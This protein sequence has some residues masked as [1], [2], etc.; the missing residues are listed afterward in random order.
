[1]TDPWTPFRDPAGWLRALSQKRGTYF[2]STSTALGFLCESVDDATLA[3]LDLSATR[4]I[5]VGAEPLEAS[6]LARFLERFSVTG[7]DPDLICPAYGMAEAS[8]GITSR[9]RD[10]P[11]RIDCVNRNALGA[12]GEVERVASDDPRCRRIFA[13]GTPLKGIALRVVNERGESL[14]DAIEGEI[15]IAGDAVISQYYGKSRADS[16]RGD[17]FRTGDLGYLRDGELYLTGRIKQLLIVNGVKYHAEDCEHC[18]IGVAAIFRG[19]CVAIDL[20]EGKY[21]TLVVETQEHDAALRRALSDEVCARIR[22]HLGLHRAQVAL[23]KPRTIPYTT[24]GKPKRL[25]LRQSILGGALPAGA[26]EYF[27]SPGAH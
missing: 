18:L 17:W 5:C 19:R 11:L 9:R 23:A 4:F 7:I 6:T 27:D 1:L 13:L 22:H 25:V 26:L 16:H 20:T 2:G 21:M 14:A 12:R 15:E 3:E 24:S 8:L 10:Q